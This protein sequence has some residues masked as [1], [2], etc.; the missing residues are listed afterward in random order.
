M[1]DILTFNKRSEEKSG[2]EIAEIIKVRVSKQ[3]CFVIKYRKYN[4]F[5]Y[6]K[7][8]IS[9]L[10]KVTFLGNDWLFCFVSRSKLACFKNPLAMVTSLSEFHFR[11]AKFILFIKTKEKRFLC[12]LWQ[13]HILPTDISQLIPKTALFSTR[14]FKSWAMKRKIPLKFE[15]K[16]TKLETTTQ[17]EFPMEGK[18]L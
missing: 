15:G 9:N 6:V 2:K 11:R 5:T 12:E 18:P 16:K 13:Q 8:T 17:S 4:R 10:L 7:N 14:I 1:W 3:I